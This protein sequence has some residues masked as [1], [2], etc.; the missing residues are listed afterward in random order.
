M[1]NKIVFCSVF[2]CLFL[3]GFVACMNKKTSK[4]TNKPTLSES[5][6]L[7]KHLNHELNGHAC[8]D[9]GLSVCWATYNVGAEFPEEYGSYFAW[10]ETDVNQ[11]YKWESYKYGS[12]NNNDVNFG[13]IK[14]N[15]IDGHKNLDLADDAARVNWGEGWRM[16]TLDEIKELCEKCIWTWKSLNGINGYEIIGTNGNSIFIPAAGYRHGSGVSYE[17]SLVYC[18]SSSLGRSYPHYACSLGSN[19][20]FYSANR[21]HGQP[22]RAVCKK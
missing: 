22:V 10:G 13:M 12:F 2:L 5:K 17:G 15:K 3:I 9:L 14:Y 18:W 4:K 11:F 8:V 16:P 6:D 1:K 20:I 19:A 21:C 7:K